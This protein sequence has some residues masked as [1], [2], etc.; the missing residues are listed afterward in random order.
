MAKASGGIRTYRTPSVSVNRTT[1]AAFSPSESGMQ[2]AAERSDKMYQNLNIFAKETGAR[3]DSLG[4]GITYDYRN[5]NVS[6]ASI[7]IVE[8]FTKNGR[9]RVAYQ[10]RITG[11]KN[12]GH[13]L[14]NQKINEVKTYN[15]IEVAHRGLQK[16]IKQANKYK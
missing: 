4:R 6:H 12:I 8:T 7:E 10:T 3:V 9:P 15:S 5:G 11:H 14:Y 16:L 1:G 13:P 2:R